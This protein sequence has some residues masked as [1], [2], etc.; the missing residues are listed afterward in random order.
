MKLELFDAGRE[1]LRTLEP[2]DPARVRLRRAPVPPDGSL[3]QERAEGLVRLLRA[4]L[5]RAGYAVEERAADEDVLVGPSAPARAGTLWLKPGP[6]GESPL[7]RTLARGFAPEDARFWALR[8]HYRAPIPSSGLE[9]QLEEARGERLRLE[10]AER[11]LAR[12][13]GAA[14]EAALAGYLRR[15][16]QALARD[17]DSGQALQCLWDALR[18]GALSAATQREALRQARCWLG[19]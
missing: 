2:A 3:A 4:T 13:P 18:P 1:S 16:R 17:L 15:L 12:A 11:S 6:G 5:E 19:L 9:A 10:Q 14:N 7:A 8:L